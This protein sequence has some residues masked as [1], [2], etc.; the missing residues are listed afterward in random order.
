MFLQWRIPTRI[1]PHN[2]AV[3]PSPDIL[4]DIEEGFYADYSSN[5][6]RENLFVYNIVLLHQ[7][8]IIAGE[9]K[10]EVPI[11]NVAKI[12]FPGTKSEL[13]YVMIIIY[14]IFSFSFREYRFAIDWKEYGS[15]YKRK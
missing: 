11:T 3:A 8:Y 15:S 1:H 13:H 12:P 7:Y 5:E 4:K 2:R 9:V 14:I 10:Y 6:R